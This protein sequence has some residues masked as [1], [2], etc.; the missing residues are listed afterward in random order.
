VRPT[1]QAHVVFKELSGRLDAQ[2]ARVQKTL[3]TDLAAFN[4]LLASKRVDP[5]REEPKKSETL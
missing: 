5:V 1:D 2:I 3:E 4:K